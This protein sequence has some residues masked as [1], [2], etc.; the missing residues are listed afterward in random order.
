VEWWPFELHPEI[1][2]EGIDRSGRSSERRSGYKERLSA[3]AAEDGLAFQS[4]T[5]VPNSRWSLEAGEFAREQGAFAPY[6]RALFEAY[7]GQGH[8]IG[9]VEV[10]AEL[11][12]AN[13]LDGAAMRAAL[14]SRRY[15][16]LVEERTEEARQWGVSG[17]PTAIFES[18]E[19]R[20]ALVGA[21]EYGVF[22][23]VA[24]RFGAAP[25][26]D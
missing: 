26:A 6:H 2:L 21:Q 10:L 20:F 5:R 11:A 13:G 16:S 22:E 24:R 17:T 25:R 8:D 3:L 4:P 1:P 19:R 18:G 7:F 12:V 23:N 14:E 15:A 9:D